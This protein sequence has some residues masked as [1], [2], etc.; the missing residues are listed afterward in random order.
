MDSEYYEQKV[1]DKFLLKH[2]FQNDTVLE[3]YC[4][5]GKVG[6]FRARAARLPKPCV[7]DVNNGILALV[8]SAIKDV[9]L[10]ECSKMSTDLKPFG[11][12]ILAGGEAV[13]TYMIKPQRTVTADLDFKFVPSFIGVP[14]TSKK[15]FGYLQYAKLYMWNMLGRAA[16]HLSNSPAVKVRLMK[17]Q[18]SSIGRCLNLDFAGYRFKRRYNLMPKLRQSNKAKPGPGDVLI[19]VEL[20]AL[21]FTY[22]G[23]SLPGIIDI[24][25]MR[26]GELGA[27]ILFGARRGLDYCNTLTGKTIRNRTL[28]VAGGHYLLDDMY[29]MVALKLRAKKYQKDRKRL[30]KFSKYALLA[31]NGEDIKNTAEFSR[32]SDKKLPKLVQT[33]KITPRMVEYIKKINPSKYSSHT[34]ALP[35]SKILKLSF[36]LKGPRG[37]VVKNYTPVKNSQYKF[38]PQ[39]MQWVHN[40][41][42]FYIRNMATH[43]ATTNIP[44]IVMLK[45]Q[46]YGFRADRDSWIDKDILQKVASIPLIGYKDKTR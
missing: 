24:A 12:L 40:S 3:R 37:M 1:I 46:L 32:L 44:S 41:S 11:Y 4:A 39:A 10:T 29:I 42:K 8:N 5:E 13:N 14:V 9:L 31:P 22:K 20:M 2:V 36:P 7:V 33:K 26:K 23:N 27:G 45:P 6:K 38:D 16:L 28:P 25:Y 17:L 19:D 34:V 30:D 43:R 15:Y 21:D 18:K 35:R